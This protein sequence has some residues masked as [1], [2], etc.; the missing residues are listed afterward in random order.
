MVTS[1]KGAL[2]RG[3][4]NFRSKLS[5][6]ETEPVPCFVWNTKREIPSDFLKGRTTIISFYLRHKGKPENLAIHFHPRHPVQR[7]L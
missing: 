5:K 7:R 2:S 6:T 4:L 3:F 1:V